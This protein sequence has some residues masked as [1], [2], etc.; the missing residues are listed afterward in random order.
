VAQGPFGLTEKECEALRLLARG[1]DAKSA[2]QALG[3]SV[4]TVNERLAEARRK[5]GVSS[6]RAAA[7]RLAEQENPEILGPQYFGVEKPPA[8]ELAHPRTVGVRPFPIWWGV[9]LMLS[10]TLIVAALAVLGGAPKSGGPATAPRV[11][12]TSPAAGAVVPAGTIALRV[13]FDR[14]MRPGSYSFVRKAVETYP[15]C[16]DNRPVQSADGRTFTLHCRLDAGRHYEIWF[17][18]PP[19]MN[20]VDEA[21]VAAS[22]YQLLFHTR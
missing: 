11:V 8:A 4:H 17:N 22:P 1:H 14:P 5:V 21:G 12:S 6:S 13:T 9:L 19:Y 16:G 3:L 7:R 15:D 20:F 18:S 2:A 10:A